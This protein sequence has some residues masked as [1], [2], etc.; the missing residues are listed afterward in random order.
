MCCN[1]SELSELSPKESLK[2]FV[3]SLNAL[4]KIKVHLLCR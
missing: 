2:Y 3:I 4:N 1:P